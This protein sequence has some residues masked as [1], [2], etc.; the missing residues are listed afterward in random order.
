MPRLLARGSKS[1][2]KLCRRKIRFT[3]NL[4]LFWDHTGREM[5]IKQLKALVAIVETGSFGE[6][7]TRLNLTQS[8]I[9]HQIRHLEEELGETL[10]I[11]GKP[12]VVPSATGRAVLAS[13]YVVLG[14]ITGIRDLSKV[15]EPRELTGQ[16]TVA[17]TSVGMTYLFG[18]LCEGFMKRYPNVVLGFRS[19]DSAEEAT[20]SV[21][22]GSADVGFVP[23]LHE[24]PTLQRVPL[25]RTED[26]L[27]VG[28]RHP[29]FRRKVVSV[30]EIRKWPFVRFHPGSGSRSQSDA[31]FRQG[32]GY[33]PIITET[34][35]MEFVKRIV[36]MG[37]ATA[38]IPIMTVAEEVRKK[39]LKAL[40]IK[41]F[42]IP[43]E[44]GIVHVRS[45]RMRVLDA[46]VSYCLTMR[47]NSPRVF[48]V[49]NLHVPFFKEPRGK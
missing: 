13:A 37:G 2:V 17:A 46:L 35:D 20:R 47:G 40:R 39:E 19:A 25:G 6:A 42:P 4:R 29:L 33:P 5:E 34:N 27:I 36:G 16:I 1:M 9:S 32:G 38:I 3:G 41:D 8:A 28:R 15:G 30:E 7:A 11:R 49:D 44:F 10:L 14:E 22:K 18:D 31:V 45:T 43:V 24:H 21:E 12:R 26:A 48:S 23:F